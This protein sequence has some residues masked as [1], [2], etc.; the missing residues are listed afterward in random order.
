MSFIS[1]SPVAGTTTSRINLPVL[2]SVFLRGGCLRS[3][4]QL[5][6]TKETVWRVYPF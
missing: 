5:T 4:T 6:K 2:K 3:K 1:F